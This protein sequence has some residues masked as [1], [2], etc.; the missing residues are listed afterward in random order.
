MAPCLWTQS[1]P[2][3]VWGMLRSKIKRFPSSLLWF[4]LCLYWC[5]ILVL[6]GCF[7]E[8]AP[9]LVSV[10]W[11]IT[12]LYIELQSIIRIWVFTIFLGYIPPK[13][14]VCS[15]YPQCFRRRSF[16]GWSLCTEWGFLKSSMDFPNDW[17]TLCSMSFLD[18]PKLFA[19]HNCPWRPLLA[20]GCEIL[21]SC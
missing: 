13:D 17:Y 18:L 6:G 9:S 14:T 11:L 7:E 20:M 8:K 12:L 15:M 21:L 5:D 10:K 19:R 1:I 3:E 2:D 16:G 4:P